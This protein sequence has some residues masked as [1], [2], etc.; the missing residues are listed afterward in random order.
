MITGPKAHRADHL[1]RAVP[2]P[3][4]AVGRAIESENSEPLRRDFA[5]NAAPRRRGRL[6]LPWLEAMMPAAR[7]QSQAPRNPVRMAML[8]MPNGVNMAHWYPEGRRPRLRAL[9]DARAAGR[10]EGSDPRAEQ[11]LERGRQGRRRPLRQRGCDAHLRDHQ[12]DARRRH[13]ERH[14][15]GP[16][17]R[18]TAGR[19]HAAALDRARRGAGSGRGG[20]GRRVHA[21]LRVAHLLG[22]PDHAA[23]RAR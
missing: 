8:Y 9:H 5:Q 10:P 1:E 11:S 22:Q 17:G 14:V 21:D 7:A 20:P 16:G 23:G 19:P 13:R 6:G 15:G 12:E 4:A 2:V 18:A 3:A